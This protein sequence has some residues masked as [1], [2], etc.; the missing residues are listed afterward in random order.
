MKGC[1]GAVQ[2]IYHL[3]IKNLDK[4]ESG[5]NLNVCAIY[6][7]WKLLLNMN[8]LKLLTTVASRELTKEGFIHM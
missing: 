1:K 3:N 6:D 2:C 5:I 4:V 8:G 7:S